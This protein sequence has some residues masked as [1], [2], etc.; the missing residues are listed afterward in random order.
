MS[1]LKK[2]FKKKYPKN[3]IDT[4]DD[5]V[6]V[7]AGPEP[8]APEEPEITD[9]P[10]FEEVYAGPE[11]PVQMKRKRFGRVYAG[12]LPSKNRRQPIALVYDGPRII[13]KK[14]SP[15]IEGVYAGP[16]RMQKKSEPMECVYAGPEYFAKK[17]DTEL[18]VICEKC[19]AENKFGA[20]TCEKC[21]EKL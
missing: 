15:P 7:Y 12:P 10:V 13:K 21:G 6:D 18:L 11:E 4:E 3:K 2:L 8:D 5:P 17:D 19:G 20:E 16:R 14:P 1:F 9:E